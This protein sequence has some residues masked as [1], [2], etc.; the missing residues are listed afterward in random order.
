MNEI[1][2]HK[3]INQER[4][5]LINR[6]LVADLLRQ[7]GVCSRATLAQLSGLKQATITNIIGEFIECG[8]VVETGLMSGCKGRRS[9][10]VTL[11]D[12]LYKVIGIRMT[13]RA[14]YISIAGLSGKVYAVE[15]Y[16][17]GPRD[18]VQN[19][20]SR[21]RNAIQDIRRENSST[22]IPA[23]CMAMPGPY[24]ED[25][26]QLLFVT[27]LSGW[28]N[29]P[30]KKALTEGFDIP[31]YIA[32]D[33]NASAFAQLW[34]R[35][36][37][38]GIRNMIYV[39]AGQ[40]IGCGI[41]TDGK[42]VLGQRGIAGEFGHNTINYRGALCECGNRGCLEKY[43]STLALRSRIRE[44][45]AAG[46]AS[47]LQ[48]DALSTEAL[49]HAV[50]QGD[51]VACEEYDRVC[52]FLSIGI[53]N[54]INQLNPGIIVIGDE[55]AEIAP[56]RMLATVRERVKESVHTLSPGEVAIEVNRLPGSPVL[57]GAAAFA[58]QS[59]LADPGKLI[60]EAAV[61]QEI[62]SAPLE[63]AAQ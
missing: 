42:L 35:S 48:A 24:R 13:R 38:Y 44:R 7:E 34:Y 31:I 54:L 9:I 28:Q 63:L 49:A 56:D 32:N 52:E 22:H 41:I 43:C 60:Q 12:D 3:S 36:K 15:E 58:A 20:I 46:E 62:S 27:E 39:L 17:I 11:N 2:T 25:R 6:A 23:V 1:I 51:P 47:K 33:A 61:S 26:D 4:S 40:G 45:L 57:L 10:G 50:A 5:Q 37:E 53:T 18:D 59:V 21:I 55:L 30:I 14:F 19:T 8:L 16:P 29:F